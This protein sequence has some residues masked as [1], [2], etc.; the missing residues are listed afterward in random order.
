M[1]WRFAGFDDYGH[2]AWHTRPIISSCFEEQHTMSVTDSAA[3]QPSLRWFH[4]TPDRCVVPLLVVEGCL[5]L[6]EWLDWFPKG[7]AVL[8][9]LASVVAA[10]LLMFLWCAVALLFRRRFQFGIRSLLVFTLVCSLVCSW[11]AVKMKQARTQK[12]AVA[13]ILKQSGRVRYDCESNA[14][15][16]GVRRAKP[17]AKT[18]L[19]RLFGDDMFDTV[20]EVVTWEDAALE[21]IKHL[22]GLQSL[23]FYCGVGVTDKGLAQLREVPQ[24]RKL[25]FGGGET[26]TEAGMANLRFLT[27]LH[28]LDIRF[29]SLTV[30]S[31]RHLQGLTELEDLSLAP[32]VTDAGLVY[33]SGLSKLSSLSVRGSGVTDAA[34]I[35]LA[36]L[37]QLRALDLG[38]TRVTGAGLA[39]LGNLSGLEELDLMGTQVT[40]AGLKHLKGSTQLKKLNLSY[41]R[42]TDTGLAHV[43]SL[44]G[45]E[46]LSL[47]HC[48]EIT[49]AGME[50]LRGLS[51]LNWLSLDSTRITG[52]GLKH[53]NGLSLLRTL[54]VRDDPNGA[55]PS[56]LAPGDL[57]EL[58]EA[59]PELKIVQQ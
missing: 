35:H 37:T 38:G 53:L 39:N 48:N 55:L 29:S 36:D 22:P 6:A 14:F 59:L 27:H 43:G 58:Q 44:S 4:L 54:S 11:L 15:G 25:R 7:Y 8:S 12:E 57:K 51:R 20:V 41:T 9:G 26:V 3:S 24:L 2:F 52:A 33:L 30:A 49:D 34:L 40:D 42:V 13:A 16:Q 21:H 10:T 32:E 47:N 46:G 31:M 56:R 23:D 28:G 45:L 19:R 5:L 17:P 1:R 50:H 18:W